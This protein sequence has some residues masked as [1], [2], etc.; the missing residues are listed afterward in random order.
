M[1]SITRNKLKKKIGFL[2][3]GMKKNIFLNRIKETNTVFDIK[4]VIKYFLLF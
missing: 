1:P 4:A 2:A 3:K